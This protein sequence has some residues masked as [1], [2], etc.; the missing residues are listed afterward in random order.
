MKM[1]QRL[2]ERLNGWQR[3]GIV[4][5]ILWALCAGIHTHNTDVKS[6][7]D[8]AAL[9]Y[10]VCTYSQMVAHDSNLSSCDQKREE[11]LATYRKSNSGNAMF[12]ALA[13]IPFFWVI[14]FILL[15]VWRAQVIGFRAIV[16]W[17]AIG[18]SKKLFVVF[19]SLISFLIVIFGIT[20][21]LNL[22]VDTQVPVMLSPFLDVIPSVDNFVTVNG[23]WTRTDLTDDSIANPLQTSHI[24][25]NKEEKKCTEAAASV[26][27]GNVHVLSIDLK[28]YDIQYGGP[29]L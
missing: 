17:A 20:D 5:S 9:T 15:H 21:V 7:N 26:S 23:T 1:G 14:T 2:N 13:P 22:Y 29:G 27:S 11:T 28:T 4:L 16:P 12:V 10:K 25:C 6:A 8:A 3:I 19:C 24:E 18:W